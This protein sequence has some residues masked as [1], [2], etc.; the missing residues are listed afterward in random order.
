[1]WRSVFYLSGWPVSRVNL[2][3]HFALRADLYSMPRAGSPGKKK[4]EW[5]KH[6]GLFLRSSDRPIYAGPFGLAECL[7]VSSRLY[8]EHGEYEARAARCQKLFSLRS[9]TWISSPGCSFRGG[10]G[11]K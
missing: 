6:P 4:P 10:E 7:K 11:C 8:R 1:M 3:Y 5:Y 9:L 2:A